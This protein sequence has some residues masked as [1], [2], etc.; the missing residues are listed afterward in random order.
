V[1][2]SVVTVESL[3]VRYPDGT[4]VGLSG[5]PFTI[6]PGERVALLGANGSGK[7]TLIRAILGLVRPEGGT[8]R[9]LGR[10]PVREFDLIRPRLS[11]VMQDVEAQLLAPTVAEDIAFG[12]EGR[13]LTRAEMQERVQEMACLFGLEALL[14][15]VPHYLSGGERRKVALAGALATGPDLL[16]LDEPFAGLDPR[17]RTELIELVRAE[18]ARRNMA[19]LLSTHEVHELPDLVDTV[20]VLSPEGELRVR[21]APAAV[22]GMRVLLEESNVEAP[23][24]TVLVAALTRRGLRVE[25]TNDPEALAEDLASQVLERVPARISPVAPPF[26]VH[27]ME[28]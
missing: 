16:V 4:V 6:A 23:P 24:L 26:P 13:G 11:A 22:F 12:L 25:A 14:D 7:S 10:D 20:Y 18:H 15:K 5:L 9:V 2:G 27:A 3:S 17:S 19:V 1:S 21:D 8:V 28:R